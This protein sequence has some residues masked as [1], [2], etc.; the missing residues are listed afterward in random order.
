MMRSPLGL[1]F[2]IEV[3]GKPISGATIL[4]VGPQAIRPPTRAMYGNG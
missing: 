2:T 3:D 1:I 4:V